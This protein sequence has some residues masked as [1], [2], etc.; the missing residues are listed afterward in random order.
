MRLDTEKDKRCVGAVKT[1]SKSGGRVVRQCGGNCGDKK[2]KRQVRIL[3]YLMNW[4]LPVEQREVFVFHGRN[5]RPPLDNVNAMLSFMYALTGKRVKWA[6]HIRLD[7]DPYVGFFAYRPPGRQSL[8]L[9][10][11]EEFRAPVADC[12]VLLQ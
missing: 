2:K 5:K 7:L 6:Q 1:V 8:A 10:P 11:M 9:D 4:I 3:V 12:F